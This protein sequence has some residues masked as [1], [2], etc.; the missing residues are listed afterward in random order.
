MDNIVRF[1]NRFERKT[2]LIAAAVVLLLLNVGR[3]VNNS[4]ETRRTELESKI[5]RLEQY[6]RIT[7]KADELDKRLA[8]LL[9]Q[10]GQV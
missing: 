10:K 1:F 8:R 5:I 2:L 6:K 9:K 3:L 7:G 4:F